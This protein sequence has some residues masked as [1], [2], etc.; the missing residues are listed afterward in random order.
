MVTPG[1][2]GGEQQ[3]RH[4]GDQRPQRGEGGLAQQPARGHL[5]TRGE[6]WGPHHR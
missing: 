1:G 6:A 2:G 4:P 3:R 5:D